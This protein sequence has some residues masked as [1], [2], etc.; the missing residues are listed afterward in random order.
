MGLLVTA[1]GPFSSVAILLVL[2]LIE[3]DAMLADSGFKGLNATP[4]ATAKLPKIGYFG[5]QQKKAIRPGNG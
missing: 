5:A 2:S 1:L 4:A 3:G